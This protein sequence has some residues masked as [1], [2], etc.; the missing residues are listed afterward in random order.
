MG[1]LGCHDF[2]LFLIFMLLSFPEVVRD[3][4]RPKMLKKEFFDASFP[5]ASLFQLGTEVQIGQI[6]FSAITRPKIILQCAF[7][8][9]ICSFVTLDISYFMVYRQKMTPSHQSTSSTCLGVDRL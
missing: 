8:A 6:T 7:R 3:V 4:A 2:T 5:I 1:R 9:Y